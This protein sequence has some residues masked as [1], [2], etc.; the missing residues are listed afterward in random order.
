M[1]SAPFHPPSNGEAERL[2]GVFKRAM[3][4]SV[5]EEGVEKDHAARK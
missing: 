1:T 3:Q 5:V 4:R 2:V